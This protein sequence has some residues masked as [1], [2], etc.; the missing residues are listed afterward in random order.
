[1]KKEAEL[2]DYNLW[3]SRQAEYIFVKFELGPKILED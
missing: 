1:M 3:I 2:L